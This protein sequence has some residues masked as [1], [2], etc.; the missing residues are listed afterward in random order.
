MITID[1]NMRS[2]L[3]R[4]LFIIFSPI[5]FCKK[6]FFQHNYDTGNI[7]IQYCDL[8][9]GQ[10]YWF[11]EGAKIAGKPV[12]ECQNKSNERNNRKWVWHTLY[13]KQQYDS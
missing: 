4:W 10:K 7:I 2:N 1:T 13:D 6:L 11:W 9:N 5:T 12:Q 3:Y 8:L